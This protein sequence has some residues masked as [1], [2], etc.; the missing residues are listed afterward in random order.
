MT[1]R[2]PLAQTAASVARPR[3]PTREARFRSFDGRVGAT[4]LHQRPDRYRQLDE[5]L[6]TAP[7]IARGSGLSYAAASFGEGVVVQEMT[8]FSRLLHYDTGRRTLE[9]EA[10]ATVGTVLDWAVAHGLHL[11]VVPGHPLAT[12]GGCIAAD[13]HGKQPGRDGTFRDWVESIALHL[14]EAG[15]VRVAPGTDPALFDATCGGF[16]L[17]GTIV[18]AV[19]RL[20]PLP[21][22]ALRLRDSATPSLEAAAEAL[23]LDESAI[24]Y[25]W[26]RF[27]SGRA[28][29]GSGF[30]TTGEWA[31]A[32]AGARGTTA[33][34]YATSE[35]RRYPMRLWNPLTV[36]AAGAAF[37]L[38]RRLQG[39]E[40][41]VG[42]HEACFPLA[43]ARLYFALFG[44]GGFGEMQWLVPRLA[45]EQFCAGFRKVALRHRP[46]ITLVSQK[47]FRGSARSLAMA[48]EGVLFCLDYVAAPGVE[49][50]E[51]AMDALLLDVG[52]QPNVGKDSRLA[53]AI[54]RQALPNFAGFAETL[55]RADP[56]RLN[57]SELSRRLGL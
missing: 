33:L 50:F 1:A 11:P 34:R 22:P 40:R 42:L 47:P 31:D 55:H 30:V 7:R 52:G 51:S 5:T 56:R 49:E 26:H 38:G 15:T 27:G 10:G 41:I 14:P 18:S 13:V 48:G 57:Q 8:A 6:G 46:T 39:M 25:S 9:V 19:L 36:A 43:P 2:Q 35:S 23:L 12:I 4:T 20:A 54:A 21:A 16:G 32:A 44:R 24:A 28:A 45:I 3:V 53:G 37:S 29:V 17:T